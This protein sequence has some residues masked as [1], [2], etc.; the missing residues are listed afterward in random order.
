MS[1]HISHS[2]VLSDVTGS[3]SS[4]LSPLFSNHSSDNSDRRGGI[5][6]GDDRTGRALMI[7]PNTTRGWEGGAIKAD[8]ADA[9]RHQ[10]A[11]MRREMEDGVGDDDGD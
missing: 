7:Q 2:V 6:T 11:G 9:H 3:S 8:D 1:G 10:A 4:R 5:D